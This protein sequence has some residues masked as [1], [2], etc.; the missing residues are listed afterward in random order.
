M[1]VPSR[2]V[3][4]ADTTSLLG[5]VFIACSAGSVRRGHLPAMRILLACR[6]RSKRRSFMQHMKIFHRNTA[7]GRGALWALGQAALAEEWRHCARRTA[8]RS[9]GAFRLE[10]LVEPGQVGHR[11]RRNAVDVGKARAP[12]VHHRG[13]L[14]MRAVRHVIRKERL[15]DIES[16]IAERTLE[17]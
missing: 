16:H 2:T 4:C 11:E 3:I 5:K 13:T 9:G 17:K 6:S 10:D 12:L 14:F 8:A 15:G 7:D 1:R